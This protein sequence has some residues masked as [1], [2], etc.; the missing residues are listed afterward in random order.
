MIIRYEDKY[1]PL[2]EIVDEDSKKNFDDM[3]LMEYTPSGN[4]IMKYSPLKTSFEYFSDRT[5]SFLYL[6]TV[7]RKYVK[8]FLCPSIYVTKIRFTHMGKINNFSLL[9]KP[10]PMMIHY[11]NFKQQPLQ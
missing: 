6:E 7:A 2:P 11:K 5:I 9:K 1:Y 10:K 8:T 4:V 3:F